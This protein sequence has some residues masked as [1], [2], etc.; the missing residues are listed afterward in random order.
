MYVC[1]WN[2]QLAIKFSTSKLS[3]SYMRPRQARSGSGE[4]VAAAIDCEGG[5]AEERDGVFVKSASSKAWWRVSLCLSS[6][7]AMAALNVWVRLTNSH[8]RV[9][10]TEHTPPA[11][12]HS[13][14]PAHRNGNAP[15][16]FDAS[17]IV[18]KGRVVGVGAA[19]GQ[20]SGGSNGS[21]RRGSSVQRPWPEVFIIGVP[22]AA[23]TSLFDA[24]Y[25]THPDLCA[26][27]NGALGNK[28]FVCMSVC[29]IFLYA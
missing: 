22:K 27:T 21:G 18:T 23:T 15:H 7:I 28:V 17:A 5:G 1:I 16:T 2:T 26:P 25:S 10:H 12:Y 20:S 9:F 6:A 4:G 19:Q 29:M 24:L 11:A 13:D 8:T 3:A 14:A